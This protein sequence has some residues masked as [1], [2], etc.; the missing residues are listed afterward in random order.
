MYRKKYEWPKL[1]VSRDLHDVFYDKMWENLAWKPTKCTLLLCNSILQNVPCKVAPL[2]A[3]AVQRS[4]F[5][6]KDSSHSGTFT[7]LMTMMMTPWDFIFK[8]NPPL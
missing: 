7:C 2:L 8:E 3:A 4:P 6:E 1:T 5:L